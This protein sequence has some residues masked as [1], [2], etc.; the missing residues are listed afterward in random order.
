MNLFA[1]AFYQEVIIRR[2]ESG[3][4]MMKIKGEDCRFNRKE[5]K[6]QKYLLF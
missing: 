4:K 6:F 2:H 3:F 5:S 1:S